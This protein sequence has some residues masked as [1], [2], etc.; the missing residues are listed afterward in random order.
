MAA[1]LVVVRR[2]SH[3]DVRHRPIGTSSAWDR[4]KLDCRQDRKYRDA[5]ALG[6]EERIRAVAL[7]ISRST[8]EN[9]RDSRG[10]DAHPIERLRC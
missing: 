6:G 10:D 7:P 2:C 1:A 5:R 3:L 4:R 9:F 8:R